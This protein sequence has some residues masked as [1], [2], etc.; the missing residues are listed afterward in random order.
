MLACERRRILRKYAVCVRRLVIREIWRQTWICNTWPRFP[1]SFPRLLLPT[2]SIFT[3]VFSKIIVLQCF[4][5]LVFQYNLNY[6]IFKPQYLIFKP[7]C[8]IF[9]PQ[10]SFCSEVG[11]SFRGNYGSVWTYLPFQFQ[12]RKKEREIREFEM[13]LKNLFVCAPI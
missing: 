8:S 9:K 12:M 5:L 4:Y 6:S 2:N 13:D 1:F 7:Q 3:P 10:Y 11:Y